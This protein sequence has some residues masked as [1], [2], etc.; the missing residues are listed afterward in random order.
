MK[1]S[2][3]SAVLNCAPLI[4][5]TLQSVLSQQGAE[6][7]YIVIDGGST[8]GTLEILEK[9]RPRLAALVSEPDGGI[10]EAM[11]KGLRLCSGDVAG[12]INAGDY[13]MPGALALVQG[14]F[15]KHLA[16]G[17]RMDNAILWGDVQYEKLGRVRGFRPENVMTGAFA[18]HPSMFCPLELYRR[19][20][21]YD[22]SF[23]LMGDYDFMYRAVNIAHAEVLYIPEILAFYLEGGISDRN[24]A[25]CLKEE[26]LV[27]LKYGRSPFSCRLIYLLKLLKNLP[28]ICAV[29]GH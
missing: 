27:K 6:I 20:G 18:P 25:K 9:Y 5:K 7:E 22:E 24:V 15:E 11:N 10:Y 17:G 2:I 29:S 28:G 16:S 1:F 21:F 3:V 23:R 8:D 14:M 13:Y 26:L 19:I 12:L 4:E